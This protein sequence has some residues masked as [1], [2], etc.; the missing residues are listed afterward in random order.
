MNSRGGNKFDKDGK[1]SVNFINVRN[2]LQ[3]FQKEYD[4]FEFEGGFFFKVTFKTEKNKKKEHG[5]SDFKKESS[6]VSKGQLF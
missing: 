4:F 1:V 5:I 2:T 3:I 6:V